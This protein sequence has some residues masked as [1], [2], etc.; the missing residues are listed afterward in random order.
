VNN[1]TL[2]M[3]FIITISPLLG[4]LVAIMVY[5]ANHPNELDSSITFTIVVLMNMTTAPMIS[6]SQIIKY[7]SNFKDSCETLHLLFNFVSDKSLEGYDLT[8]VLGGNRGFIHLQGC[9]FWV[10][11][12]LNQK[13][14]KN[15]FGKKNKH[16]LKAGTDALVMD[17]RGQ[18]S[19]GNYDRVE[20]MRL[21]VLGIDYSIMQE[22]QITLNPDFIN[23]KDIDSYQKVLSEID[24]YIRPGQKV[25]LVGE[26]YSGKTMFLLSLIGETE[27]LKKITNKGGIKIFGRVNYL[28][29]DRPFFITGTVKENII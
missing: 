23:N 20:S 7:S 15:L 18:F 29:M 19:V 2:F 21:D 16:L 22:P 25:G 27:F 26:S 17:I 6:L 4:V 28:S 8:D 10:N 24:F 5:T 14:I 1:I 9:D 12:K 3:D 11:K 13:I